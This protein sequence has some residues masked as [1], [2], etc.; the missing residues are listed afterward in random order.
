M[1][2]QMPTGILTCPLESIPILT[3][4]YA[5][6]LTTAPLTNGDYPSNY[7]SNAATTT[8]LDVLQVMASGRAY[9]ALFV[10]VNSEVINLM[11]PINAPLAVLNAL[12]EQ[13]HARVFIRLRQPLAF[14]E[15]DRRQIVVWRATPLFLLSTNWLWQFWR[16]TQGKRV[17]IFRACQSESNWFS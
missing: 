6:K 16:L 4:D 3:L 9:L 17:I 12:P 13:S 7:S 2:F 11:N 8:E 15:L 1:P 5:L 10:F 14:F